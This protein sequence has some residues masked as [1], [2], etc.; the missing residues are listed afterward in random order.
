MKVGKALNIKHSWLLWVPFCLDVVGE[1]LNA[2]VM[3]ANKATMPVL[4][5]GGGCEWVSDTDII[6][7]CLVSTTHLK[8]LSDWIQYRH[9]AMISPGDLFIMSGEYVF[10]PFIMTWFLLHCLESNPT[11]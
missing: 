6:H 9:T 7:S 4:Y 10:F 11:S 5:P 2:I 8:F 3:A 1:G